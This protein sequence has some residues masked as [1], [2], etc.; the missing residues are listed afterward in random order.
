MTYVEGAALHRERG[1]SSVFARYAFNEL[2]S[3]VAGW[4]ILLDYAILLAV[5]RSRRRTT[6]PSCGTRSGTGGWRSWSRS[7]VIA[8]VAMIN[9]R[10]V[11][12]R[13]LRRGLV[14]RARR[15]RGAAADHRARARRCCWTPRRDRRLDRARQLAR[16]G[17]HDLRADDR[18][19]RLHRPGGGREPRGGD[20]DDPHRPAPAASGPASR[21]SCSC[22]SGSRSSASARC[23]STAEPTRSARATSRRRCCRSRTRSTPAWL[24]DGLRAAVALT[25]VVGL[26][27]AATRR[28]SASRG[29]RTAWRRTAR[30]PAR[31]GACTRRAARRSC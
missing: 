21:R 25:A 7:R 15:H 24:A 2:V 31:S 30:S 12:V 14:R 23:R 22:T 27:V 26:L 6:W 28:C 8:V 3:F 4:A 13:Q 19:D 16:V 5:T 10:G 18:D 17:R 20:V 29:S 1:G 11:T 9:V